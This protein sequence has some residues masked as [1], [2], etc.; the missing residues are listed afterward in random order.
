[1]KRIILVWAFLVSILCSNDVYQ[2][3]LEAIKNGDSKKAVELYIKACN[4]GDMIGCHQLAYSYCWG[5]GI[6]ENKIKAEELYSKT[7]DS[8]YMESCFEL[9]HMYSKGDGIEKN[10]KKA[11]DLFKKVCDGEK[12]ATSAISCLNYKMYE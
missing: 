4:S 2:E 8:G 1:M 7:C 6:K 12:T 11:K 3:G 5:T 10:E 9:A